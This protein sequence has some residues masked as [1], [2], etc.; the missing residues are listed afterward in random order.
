VRRG[1]SNDLGAPFGAAVLDANVL[2]PAA[3]RDT[4]LRLAE[5][6]FSALILDEVVRNLIQDGRSTDAG[7][8]R[9]IAIMRREFPGADVLISAQQIGQMLNSAEDRHVL[10][11]A[12]E[13]RAGTI[14]TANLKDFPPSAL[15]AFGI[16]AVSPDTFLRRMYR[17]AP[18]LV[19]QVLRAQAGDLTNPPMSFGDILNMLFLHAPQFVERVAADVS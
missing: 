9:L 13:A 11:A 6:G 7:S 4:L 12:V 14:V 10:A 8:R 19:V 18:Q 2:Y 15:I 3:L 17:T 5:R 1:G 16:E